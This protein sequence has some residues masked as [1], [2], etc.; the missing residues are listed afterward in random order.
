MKLSKTAAVATVLSVFFATAA[1]A[2]YPE[3]PITM[4]VAWSAGGGTDAVAR[5]LAAQMEKELDVPI[6]VVNRTG[7]AGVIGH[8]AM[9][10][11]RPDGYTIG[12]A[13]LELSTYYWSGTAEFT[14]KD[15]TPIGLV[16]LDAS[17]VNVPMNSEWTDL[18]A[19]LDA[20][21]SAP[22]GTYKLTGM[23]PGAG[24]HI[25]FSGLLA[26][27][28]IDPSKVVVVPT[29]GAQPGF[30]ELAAGGAHVQPSSLP[31]AKAMMD[32]GRVKAL[33]VLS[34]K[35]LPNFPD[36]PTVKEAIGV[37]W[38]G[39]TWRGIVAPKKLPEDIAAKLDVAVHTA[40]HSEE[41]QGFMTERGFGMQYMNTGDFAA[42]LASQHES[43]GKTMALLGLN[44]RN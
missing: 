23:G 20:I 2:D 26:E 31:E 3:R 36:V 34:A 41:F 33:A 14:G 5:A 38:I 35:R 15:V 7:G 28:G 43:N 9:V 16:N 22:A 30:Q 11:A 29:Q 40:W 6:T 8:T 37:D 25:A 42:F 32:A 44:R 13:S 24:Y 19:A 18:R 21:K 39:G 10:N 12:L 17:A 27:E 1:V 4:L